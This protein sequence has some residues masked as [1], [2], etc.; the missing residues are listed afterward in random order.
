MAFNMVM[1]DNHLIFR[2]SKTSTAYLQAVQIVV[3]LITMRC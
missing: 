3:F 1:S 2:G